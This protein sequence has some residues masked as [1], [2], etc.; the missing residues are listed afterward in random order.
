VS[1]RDDYP[2]LAEW[3]APPDPVCRQLRVALDEID[4]L[5]AAN[6]TLIARRDELMRMSGQQRRD[7]IARSGWMIV[8]RNG[9]Q[10]GPFRAR[11]EAE[12]YIDQGDTILPVKTA[13]FQ[14]R[15]AASVERNES[16]LNRLSET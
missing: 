10:S 1:A 2:K 14:A 13:E 8:K 7:S 5:R 4:Q 11:A 6:E 16:I 12:P 3:A 9:K 15:L